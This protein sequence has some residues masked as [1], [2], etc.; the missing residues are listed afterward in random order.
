MF[1][2]PAMRNGKEVPRFTKITNPDV[3]AQLKAIRARM[4]PDP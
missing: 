3:I 2:E 4:Y 1:Y